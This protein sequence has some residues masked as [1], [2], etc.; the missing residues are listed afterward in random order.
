[1]KKITAALLFFILYSMS[2]FCQNKQQL[3]GIRWGST[4]ANFT[5]NAIKNRYTSRGMSY[6]MGMITQIQRP[7]KIGINA[8][9]GFSKKNIKDNRFG[10]AL[11]YIT[12]SI[13]PNYYIKK[14]ESTVFIGGYAAILASYKILNDYPKSGERFRQF[15]SGLVVGVNQRIIKISRFQTSL[16]ARLSRGFIDIRGETWQGI[17]KSYSY[18]LGVIL[19]INGSK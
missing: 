9:V 7:N 2:A 12:C 15:D 11:N 18:S 17:T 5:N 1:M 3:F 13:M 4:S 8:E 16:D 19:S 14:S 10:F 6:E